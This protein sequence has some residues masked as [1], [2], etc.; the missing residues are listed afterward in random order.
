MSP[1]SSKSSFESSGL[2]MTWINSVH[3]SIRP[4]RLYDKAFSFPGLTKSMTKFVYISGQNTPYSR[5]GFL[6]SVWLGVSIVFSESSMLF[7]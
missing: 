5:R 7:G 1:A 4:K 6:G 3:S 2:S